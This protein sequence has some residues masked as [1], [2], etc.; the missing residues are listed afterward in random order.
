MSTRSRADAFLALY[1]DFPR[2][3]TGAAIPKPVK[4]L[5]E[6][7]EAVTSFIES[8]GYKVRNIKFTPKE[9]RYIGPEPHE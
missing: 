6:F 8:R 3:V 9:G 1:L 2:D 5:M 7:E 4:E